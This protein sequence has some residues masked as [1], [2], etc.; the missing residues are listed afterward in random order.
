[1]LVVTAAGQPSCKYR[2]G[3]AYIKQKLQALT[4]KEHRDSERALLCLQEI[5]CIVPLCSAV[6][7]QT[8]AKA[9]GGQGSF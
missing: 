3:H 7:V 5:K 6:S 9:L 4:G 2:E 8:P 1:M